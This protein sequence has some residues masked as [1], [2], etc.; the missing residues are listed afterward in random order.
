M[1]TKILITLL[2]IWTIALPASVVL[3][4]KYTVT[5]TADAGVGSLRDAIT[6]ANANPGLDTVVFAILP[7]LN[8]FE[9]SG[10]NTYAVITLSSQLPTITSPLLIDGFTQTDT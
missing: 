10:L 8:T 3:G 5:T 6:H 2:A 7:A 9:A 1:K 4:N